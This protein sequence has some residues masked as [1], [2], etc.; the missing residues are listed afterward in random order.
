MQ[1]LGAAGTSWGKG[2]MASGPTSGRIQRHMYMA[3]MVWGWG[4]VGWG[5]VGWGGVGW[6]GVGWGGVDG[7]GWV[8]LGKGSRDGALSCP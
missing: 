3:I 6:G 7:V 1:P 5:G 8:R 4:G 2:T